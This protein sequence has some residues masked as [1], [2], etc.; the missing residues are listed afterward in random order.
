VFQLRLRWDFKN[1]RVCKK[2]M[3]AVEGRLMVVQNKI[4]ENHVVGDIRYNYF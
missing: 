1:S 4:E 3:K 2:S